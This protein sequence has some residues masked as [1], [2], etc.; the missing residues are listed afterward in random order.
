[1]HPCIMSDQ[2]CGRCAMDTACYLGWV[3]PGV[4][5]GEPFCET[6]TL[7]MIQHASILLHTHVSWSAHRCFEASDLP[8]F[9]FAVMHAGGRQ[10]VSCMSVQFLSQCLFLQHLAGLIQAFLVGSE[11]S[12]FEQASVLATA[13][14]NRDELKALGAKHSL[15]VICRKNL[16]RSHL[17]A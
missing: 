17:H 16:G 12:F 7:F 2:S 1:M 13:W 3:C 5:E 6:R 9:Y 10:A 14:A 4:W 11:M 15:C 8:T